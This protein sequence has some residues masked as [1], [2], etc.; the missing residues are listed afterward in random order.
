MSEHLLSVWSLDFESRSDKVVCDGERCGNDS[1][2]S[3]PLEAMKLVLGRLF[4]HLG[5]HGLAE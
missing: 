1:H 4:I 3:H 2:V 5:E